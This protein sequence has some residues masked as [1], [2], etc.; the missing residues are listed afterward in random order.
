MAGG[1]IKTSSSRRKHKHSSSAR[2][3]H[4]AHEK[5][6]HEPPSRP[7]TL[8]ALRKARLEY[9]DRP[10]EERRKN[11]KYVYDVP[12]T[13]K[14]RSTKD[15]KRDRQSV[16]SVSRRK[17][18]EPRKRRKR[19]DSNQRDA[20]SDDDYVLSEP[21]TKEEKKEKPTA[22][23]RSREHIAPKATSKRSTVSKATE[24]RDPPRRQNTEPLRRRNSCPDEER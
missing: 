13:V 22:K 3:S 11:M 15:E 18:E 8:N 4:K 20:Q 14:T 24:S 23:S 1:D 19:K 9:L 7:S 21:E 6:E 17:S 12:I 2:K 16:V 10:P 5:L